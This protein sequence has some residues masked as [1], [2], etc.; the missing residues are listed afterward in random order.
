MELFRRKKECRT[1]SSEENIR[2]NALPKKDFDAVLNFIL[3]SGK[4]I[5]DKIYS[6][7]RGDGAEM[8]TF[9]YIEVSGRARDRDEFFDKVFEFLDM[10]V[11]DDGF[12]PSF[13]LFG[14]EWDKAGLFALF[15]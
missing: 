9:Y 5:I 1:P 7:S 14:E 12:E 3:N 4:K 10:Y 15:V 11:S 6:V 2:A 8:R 13:S